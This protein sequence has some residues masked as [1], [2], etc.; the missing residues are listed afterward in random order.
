ML[1]QGIFLFL[2][3]HFFF[4]KGS[5]ARRKSSINHARARGDVQKKRIF[6]LFREYLGYLV[7]Y[8]SEKHPQEETVKRWTVLLTLILA[9]V[10]LSALALGEDTETTLW[11]ACDPITGLWGYIT[12]DGAWGNTV[13]PFFY[14]AAEPFDGSL[15]RVRFDES[16]EGYINRSGEAVY[17][18][19]VQ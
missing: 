4:Q 10:S 6:S 16:T 15:A 13:L 5:L 14:A 7:R 17:A 8:I 19:P 9:L 18:W 12:E 1:N 11:P 2:L 3:Y